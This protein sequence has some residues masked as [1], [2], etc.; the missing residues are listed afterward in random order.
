MIRYF[1]DDLRP[2]IQAQLDIRNW[3]L[4]FWD[5]VVDKTVNA[6]AKASLQAP[7]ETREMDSWCPQ[8]QQSTKKDDKD[9]KDYKKNKFS[10]NP[11]ANASLS[12]TQSFPA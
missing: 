9:S 7:S 11:P 6:K 12:G 8:G 1:R 3:D 10:Q 4:D 5:E 2:S